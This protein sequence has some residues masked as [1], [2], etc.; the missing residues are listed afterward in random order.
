MKYINNGLYYKTHLLLTLYDIIVHD[1]QHFIDQCE[2]LINK[3]IQL[4]KFK[5]YYEKNVS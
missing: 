5:K 3:K 2:N 1:N 4:D